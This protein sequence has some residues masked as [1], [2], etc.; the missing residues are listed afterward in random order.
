MLYFYSVKNK[1]YYFFLYNHYMKKSLKQELYDRC[2][3]KLE[4]RINSFENAMK[5]AQAASNSEDKSS[6][7]DKYETSRA[8]GQ[9]DRDMNA[10][11]FVEAQNEYASLLKI[12]ITNESE[13]V[14]AGSMIETN[15]GIY[16]IAAGI[17]TIELESVNKTIIVLSP[18]SPLAMAFMGKKKSDTIHFNNKSFQII[19]LS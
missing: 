7:G 9:L 12:F 6:A 14:I 19:Q 11:Q 17:G 10:K 15:I 4:E 16:F 8:M 3:I 18:R 13:K 5:N 1:S 2:K